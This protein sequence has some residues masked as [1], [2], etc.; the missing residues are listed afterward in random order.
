MKG[1]TFF[2]TLLLCACGVNRRVG[3]DRCDGPTRTATETEAL[4]GNL[5]MLTQ[6]YTRTYNAAPGN[7]EDLIVYI[8]RMDEDSRLVYDNVYAYLQKHKASLEIVSDS[9]VSIYDR[10]AKHGKPLIRTALRNPC[11]YRTER[12][13]FFD[14]QGR[15][16]HSDSWSESVKQRVAVEYGAHLLRLKKQ[17]IRPVMR[18]RILLE[19]TAEGLKN[20]CTGEMPDRNESAYLAHVYRYL[21]SLARAND[22]SRITVPCFIDR[23]GTRPRQEPEN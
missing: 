17:G 15:Y 21:D 16:L 6:Y 20:L 14:R 12:V 10:H 23:S 13:D 5:E 1:V 11:E 18:E 19:Y 8:E 2:L 3:T 9:I 22:L 7:I 4:I